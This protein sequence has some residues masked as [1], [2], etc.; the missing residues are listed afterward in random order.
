MSVKEG[1]VTVAVVAG[2]L[3]GGLAYLDPGRT[4]GDGFE[5]QRRQ[6]QIDN[7]ADAEEMRHEGYRRDGQTHVDSE[8]ARRRV[9]GEIRPAEPKVRPRVRVRL[10]P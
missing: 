10:W 6:Q 8:L 7:A 2:L 3:T 4:T 9:P 1:V 5:E